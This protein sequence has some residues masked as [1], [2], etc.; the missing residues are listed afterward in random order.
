MAVVGLFGEKL[1][2]AVGILVERSVVAL[3]LVVGTAVVVD[4]G[5]GGDDGDDAVPS[6]A[7]F[8]FLSPWLSPS[9]SFPSS[10]GSFLS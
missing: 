2:V 4:G 1:V 9:L 3:V 8:P 5:D 6:R 7:P 10:S